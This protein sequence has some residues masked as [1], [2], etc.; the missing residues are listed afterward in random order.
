[1]S[2]DRVQF[3]T[4]GT[5]PTVSATGLPLAT[6]TNYY[7]RVADKDTFYVAIARQYRQVSAS[8]LHSFTTTGSG[9]HTV[10]VMNRSKTYFVRSTN[11]TAN[12]FEFSETI[13][14]AAVNTSGTQ[15]G[16]HFSDSYSREPFGL[17]PGTTYYVVNSTTRTF[18]L[19]STVGGSAINTTSAQ[20]GYLTACTGNDSGTGLTYSAQDAFFT[21]QKAVDVAAGI[22]TGAYNVIIQFADGEYNVGANG[23]YGKTFVGS[24]E[25]R[26]TGNSTHLGNVRLR[27]TGSISFNACLNL[28]GVNTLYKLW[29]FGLVSDSLATSWGIMLQNGSKCS[30]KDLELGLNGTSGFNSLVRSSTLSVLTYELPAGILHVLAPTTNFYEG[31]S[32][33]VFFTVTMATYFIGSPGTGTMLFLT[34]LSSWTSNPSSSNPYYG[35]IESGTQFNISLN[36]VAFAFGSFSAGT[37]FPGTAGT[38]AT[39]GQVN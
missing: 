6:G 7:V 9:T 31:V 13:G 30:A 25:C 21:P 29:G 23:I 5:L 24:G 26:L 8:F 14:G 22:D 19:A 15:S 38:T 37:F 2:G 36:S 28:N 34:S 39:G 18:Q 16:V 3:S 4:T 20:I 27:L 12:T 32:N 1:M 17:R 10:T 11:K 33:G 35:T